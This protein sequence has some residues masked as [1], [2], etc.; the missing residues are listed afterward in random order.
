MKKLTSF[1]NEQSEINEGRPKKDAAFQDT[2]FKQADGKPA[3]KNGSDGV[4]GLNEP[5][6][7]IGRASCRERV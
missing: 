6:D 5:K 3:D 2:T 1:I 4:W 7:E